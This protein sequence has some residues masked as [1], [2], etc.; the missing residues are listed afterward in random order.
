MICLKVERQMLEPGLSA[1]MKT[2]EWITSSW[3]D[4][5]WAGARPWQLTNGIDRL[6]RCRGCLDCFSF[7]SLLHSENWSKLAGLL[8][9]VWEL[10]ILQC[11]CWVLTYHPQIW[12]LSFHLLSTFT[13][14][15][16]W[17][18]TQEHWQPIGKRRGT[19]RSG[20]GSSMENINFVFG[21]FFFLFTFFKGNVTI[22][23][24]FCVQ[25]QIMYRCG[26]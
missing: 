13:L 9:W 14:S 5:G 20:P 25:I 21:F 18:I 12:F 24:C 2:S 10:G 22:F 17:L 16:W 19:Q 15:V 23:S 11:P 3:E 6:E 7:S 26:R 8:Q 1:S 4:R